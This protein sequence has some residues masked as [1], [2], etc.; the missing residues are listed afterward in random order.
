MVLTGRGHR[1]FDFVSCTQAC[2]APGSRQVVTTTTRQ[3]PTA[4]KLAFI[5][6]VNKSFVKLPV[7]VLR[8]IFD[9]AVVIERTVTVQPPA[10]RLSRMH[11]PLAKLGQLRLDAP[12]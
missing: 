11:D 2:C 10:S 9:L 7:E 4:Q 3:L 6:A 1:A 5:L 8:R 12:V